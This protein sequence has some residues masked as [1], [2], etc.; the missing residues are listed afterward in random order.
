MDLRQ[1]AL[2]GAVALGFALAGGM[3]ANAAEFK[4]TAAGQNG[5][6]DTGSGLIV[7]TPDGGGVYSVTNITGAWAGQTITGPSVYAG[8]DNEV[9][10]GTPSLDFPGLAFT[11][12][13]GAVYNFYSDSDANLADTYSCG[14]AGY[15]EIGPGAPFTSG[16]EAP[17]PINPIS[18]TLT[19]VPEPVTW[20]MML[21]GVGMIGGGLRVSRRK[22]ATALTAA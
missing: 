12:A 21:L 3:A 14:F 4:W 19:A 20:A 10:T 22:D 16:L 9:F 15:C 13:T 6:H 17:D 5:D 18:F 7:A 11:V 8:S 1:F 2:G